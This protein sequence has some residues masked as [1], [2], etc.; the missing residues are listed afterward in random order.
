M[1]T[2]VLAM[3][4]SAVASTTTTTTAPTSTEEVRK[5]FTFHALND[6]WGKSI[7]AGSTLPP[8]LF[9]E[10]PKL[11]KP[12]V[13][14]AM[15][16]YPYIT[17]TYCSQ[18]DSDTIDQIA[19]YLQQQGWHKV[20]MHWLEW[21][22]FTTRDSSDDRVYFACHSTGEFSGV[23]E[24]TEGF[25]GDSIVLQSYPGQWGFTVPKLQVDTV[26]TVLLAHGW[27]ESQQ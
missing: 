19:R 9:D 6:E 16:S 12:I 17:K 10:F 25:N 21:N 24:N 23:P 11:T 2:S 7:Y 8:E 13:W 15:G 14:A 26:R 22:S 4:K 3:L 18:Y 27:H 20:P 5:Q 1:L